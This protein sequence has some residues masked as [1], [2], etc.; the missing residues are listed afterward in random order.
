MPDLRASFRRLRTNSFKEN[1]KHKGDRRGSLDR[2]DRDKLTHKKAEELKSEEK[3]SRKFSNE[4][5][6]FILGRTRSADDDGASGTCNFFSGTSFCGFS[7]NTK[8]TKSSA[9]ANINF[10]EKLPI[11]KNIFRKI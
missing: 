7:P 4:M 5:K 8:F 6:H 11:C 9:S 3:L 1:E 2:V 10:W